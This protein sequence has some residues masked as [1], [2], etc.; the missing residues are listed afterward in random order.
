M[1]TNTITPRTFR[2]L[3][4]L[5]LVALGL[6]SMGHAAPV[7]FNDPAAF[8]AQAIGGIYTLPT[9]PPSVIDNTTPWTVGDA[10]Y[11]SAADGLMLW[12][13]GGYGANIKFLYAVTK[14]DV[15]LTGGHNNVA[16]RLGAYKGV[17]DITLSVNGGE[18]QT[19]PIAGRPDNTF[20]GISN[21]EPITSITVIMP[22]G[23]AGDEIDLVFALTVVAVNETPLEVAAGSTGAEIANDGVLVRAY[24]FGDPANASF[25]DVT[26]NGIPFAKGISSIDWDNGIITYNDPAMSGFNG[27]TTFGDPFS[28]ITDPEYSQ[29]VR[30]F[31]WGWTEGGLT[32]S[33]L[34]P[35]HNYRLQLMM[36]LGATGASLTVGGQAWT[37]ADGNNANDGGKPA[38]LTATWTADT[39]PLS[40]VWA[41]LNDGSFIGY[42]LHDVTSGATTY[43]I[44]GTVTLDSAGLSGV[45]VSAGA[46]HTATTASDGTYTI[47]GVPDGTY[48]VTPSL[49]GYTFTP[50]SQS[51]TVSGANQPGKDFAAMVAA[52]ATVTW[53]ETNLDVSTTAT[54]MQIANDGTLVRAYHFGGSGITD[55]TVNDVLFINGSP[56][57]VLTDS[58]MTGSWDGG[59][60]P[61]WDGDWNL[62]AIANADYRQLVSAMFAFKH[63]LGTPAISASTIT[64]GGLSVGH[65]YRLQLI[66]NN[67][68]GGVFDVEGGTHTLAGNDNAIPVVLAA[69][70]TATDDTLNVALVGTSHPDGPHFCGYAL[71][72]LAG[73]PPVSDYTTWL[74]EY[75]FAEGADTTPTGDADGDGLDNQQEYAFGL[76]PT[77]GSSVNPCSPLLGTQFSYTRRAS[78]GLD[79]TVE[80]ST[81]LATWN[82]A[83]ATQVSGTPDPNGVQIV[84]VTVSN[85]PVDGKLFVR[86]QA[87]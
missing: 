24:H 9:P 18:A 29:L 60:G 14:L 41:A 71:H 34:T 2:G 22:A 1:K 73:A 83:T 82:P 64:V 62:G 53:A 74:G 66:S 10:T 4:A 25:S 84:T 49:T 36:A 37:F 72:E 11:A 79:Y 32:L 15:V 19:Y 87:Q 6:S 69:T 80:Y 52:V 47:T 56:S 48:T 44:S 26:V 51:V 8:A 16:F 77:K 12:D 39:N 28:S 67:P 63:P 57:N 50:A 81:D 35:G 78:S 42:A 33:G 3:T 61:G 5:A 54:G 21:S 43:S 45:T 86:V 30:S 7:V 27:G 40:V 38:M 13:D 75:T 55:V 58:A 68:R 17:Q 65:K 31:I 59:W 70:W 20:F 85:A 23:G 46:G 76:D